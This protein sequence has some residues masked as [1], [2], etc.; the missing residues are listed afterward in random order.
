MKTQDA[1]VW[2]MSQFD[3]AELGDRRRSKGSFNWP[4]R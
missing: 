2:V 4:T 3:G 1:K